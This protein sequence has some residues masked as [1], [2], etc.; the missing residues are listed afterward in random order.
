M[1]SETRERFVRAV[2]EKL[3]LDRI[4]E[5]HFF[6]PIRQGQIETGVAV[7]AATPECGDRSPP[8]GEPSSAEAAAS[9]SSA[10]LSGVFAPDSRLEVYTATYHWTR[11]GPERGRWQVDVV[12]E[13]WAPL[14]AVG[15]VVRG[16]RERAG[17]VLD[18]DRLTARDLHSLV[19]EPAWQTLG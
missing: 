10:T 4:V 14:E 3:P 7:I 18:A 9:P 1:L 15:S 13:A 6:P 5:I 2:L 12:A 8:S 17:E 19:S 16:V 11:K